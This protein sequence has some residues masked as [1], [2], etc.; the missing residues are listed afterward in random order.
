VDGREIEPSPEFLR[1]AL[2]GYLERL[3]ALADR[4][5]LAQYDEHRRHLQKQLREDEM[6]QR[7]LLLEYLT[8]AVAPPDQAYLQARSYAMRMHWYSLTLGEKRYLQVFDMPTALPRDVAEI[9]EK[10]GMMA[11]ATTA[12]GEEYIRECRE[13]G[14][15]IPPDWGA[16]FPRSVRFAC[17]RC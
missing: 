1:S 17:M 9:G 13:A 7:F 6:S 3:L 10:G 11:K 2:D 15:P 16:R 5:V 14:V 12:T 8:G 4:R